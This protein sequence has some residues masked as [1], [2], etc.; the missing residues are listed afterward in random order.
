MWQ[1][2]VKHVVKNREKLPFCPHIFR[3]NE[4]QF[5]FNFII[6]NAMF[7]VTYPRFFSFF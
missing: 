7:S 4:L 6:E 3:V 5:I 1:T 2:L